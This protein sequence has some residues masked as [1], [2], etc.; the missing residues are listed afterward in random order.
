MITDSAITD[1]AG[2]PVAAASE[3]G[4]HMGKLARREAL[5]GYLTI[6]P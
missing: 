3:K 6:A 4:V 5:A 2:E 1:K